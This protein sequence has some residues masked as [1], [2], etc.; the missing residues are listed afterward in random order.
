MLDYLFVCVCVCVCVLWGGEL[1]KQLEPSRNFVTCQGHG[2][3][4]MGHDLEYFFLHYYCTFLLDIMF[5][6]YLFHYYFCD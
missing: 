2:T 5:L 6:V 3:G 4:D 1:I